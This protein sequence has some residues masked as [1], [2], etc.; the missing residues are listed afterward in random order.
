MLLGWK[1]FSNVALHCILERS[2]GNKQVWYMHAVEQYA[3]WKERV[4]SYL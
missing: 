3:P 4:K 2:K 1:L